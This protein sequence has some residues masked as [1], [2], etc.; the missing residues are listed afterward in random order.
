MRL[1]VIS[2]GSAGNAILVEADGA[3]VLLDPGLA[4]REIALRLERSALETR[5]R[6]VNAVVCSHEHGD[7]AGSVPALA[8]AG[9]AVFATT[10]TCRAL[11]LT[12]ATT[13]A[14]EPFWVGE[15]M[16]TPVPLPHDAAEHVGFR[17][18]DGDGCA[19]VILDC[20]SATARVAERFADCEILV[21]ETNYDE[22]MLRG[23]P[24]PA[25]L[26]RRIGGPLGHLSNAEAAELLRLM[27]KPAA[28][29]LVLAHLSEEN[30]QPRLARAAIERTLGE[31]SLRP[32]LLVSTRERSVAPISIKKRRVTVMPGVDDRQLR[33]AFSE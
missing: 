21:L 14:T 25:G 8:S 5:L 29:A 32:R 13:V 20:G 28:Q 2:T 7:H 24:Y 23:G 22:D 30:N 18:E 6:D 12:G 10:G 17:L 27:E 15:L 4:P 16:I 31:R 26:K 1:T 3:C 19:G 9:I 11:N 33:F